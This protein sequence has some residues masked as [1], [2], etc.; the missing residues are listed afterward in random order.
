MSS[1]Y[2]HRGGQRPRHAACVLFVP[3]QLHQ[4]VFFL[5]TTP[6]TPTTQTTNHTNLGVELAADA[7]GLQV[8]SL[9]VCVRRAL[10]LCCELVACAAIA[11]RGRACKSVITVINSYFLEEQFLINF[12]INIQTYP[13][14]RLQC[15]FAVA[16]LFAWSGV[17][18]VLAR[19][20]HLHPHIR[21]TCDRGLVRCLVSPSFTGRHWSLSAS[22][23]GVGCGC[24]TRWCLDKFTHSNTLDPRA[25]INQPFT[26]LNL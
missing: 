3:R 11:A 20:P 7:F 2:G 22:N 8:R 19:S 16:G 5:S 23:K 4:T 26:L 18:E 21:T 12:L 15:V 14:L 13:N 25:D 1:T 17:V 9:A 6:T 24:W 10:R